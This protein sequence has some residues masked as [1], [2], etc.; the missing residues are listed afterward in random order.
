MNKSKVFFAFL[1]L[2]TSIS[3]FGQFHTITQPTRHYNIERISDYTITSPS[4][5]LPEKTSQ[6]GNIDVESEL[7]ATPEQLTSDSLRRQY[8]DRYLSVSFPMKQLIVN[9][10]FG[11][12]KDPFTGKKRSHNGLDL[13]ASCDEVYA[14]L[15]GTVKKTGEDKRSGKYIIIQYGEFMVSYCH[16]SRIWVKCGTRVK[17]GE[18]VGI[19]GN[20]GRS[21][22][23]HLHITCRRDNRY[24]DPSILIQFIKEV[25]ENTLKQLCNIE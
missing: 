8:I 1:M 22:G 2:C 24:V 7:A 25:K 12:R 5:P 17:P 18:V 13:R 15:D 6:S 19:T 14:M 16:L 20:T 10:P 11:Q 9:S 3:V 23:E 4:P 21:T